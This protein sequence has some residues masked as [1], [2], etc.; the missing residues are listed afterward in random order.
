MLRKVDTGTPHLSRI[1]NYWLGGKDYFPADQEAGDQ[2]SAACP[3]VVSAARD[4]QD[5]VRRVVT[6]LTAEEGVRQFLDIGG[7]L[8]MAGETHQVAQRVAPGSRVV[9]VEDARV[10]PASV[11]ELLSSG[12][13]G[14]TRYV[15]GNFRAPA[16]ILQEAT[17]TLDLSRPVAF[18]L[19]GMAGPSATTRRCPTSSGS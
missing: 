19:L 17:P 16:A 15:E 8:P 10:A 11:R 12:P 7:G 14:A 3:V 9:Y 6:W 13:D 1:W 18:M 2:L 4:I 5:F